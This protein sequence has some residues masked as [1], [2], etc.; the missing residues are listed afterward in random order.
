[1]SLSWTHC[2]EM[3]H[4]GSGD[5]PNCKISGHWSYI[6]WCPY[7]LPFQILPLPFWVYTVA[8]DVDLGIVLAYKVDSRE[9]LVCCA[10]CFLNSAEPNYRKMKKEYL[11]LEG[12]PFISLLTIWVY[13]GYSQWMVKVPYS[14]TGSST[15]RIPVCYHVWT[16]EIAMTC[17]RFVPLTG[18][19]KLYLH[20]SSDSSGAVMIFLAEQAHCQIHHC[21]RAHPRPRGVSTYW[22]QHCLLCNDHGMSCWINPPWHK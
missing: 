19:Q 4:V 13:S 6:F 2:W 12:Q 16:K 3:T 18:I 22:R 14:T 10:N 21:C 11:G 8:P 9:K 17:G 7:L 20:R 15:R 1:M 5:S